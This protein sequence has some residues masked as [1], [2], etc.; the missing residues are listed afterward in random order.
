MAFGLPFRSISLTIQRLVAHKATTR[1]RRMEDTRRRR[2]ENVIK[3][4][5]FHRFEFII[6]FNLVSIKVRSLCIEDGIPAIAGV[7]APIYDAHD[8][9]HRVINSP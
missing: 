5:T 9:L 6:P 8:H 2:N 3:W 1:F 7:H 4:W